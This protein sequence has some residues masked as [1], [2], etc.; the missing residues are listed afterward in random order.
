MEAGSHPTELL[1]SHDHDPG[2]FTRQVLTRDH[3]RFDP[4]GS[5]APGDL[6]GLFD[7]LHGNG[8]SGTGVGA[9]DLHG[10]SGGNHSLAMPNLQTG[11]LS[12]GMQDGRV[13]WAAVNQSAQVRFWKL[14][15][16]LGP[17]DVSEFLKLQ[18]PHDDAFEAG[19]T[20]QRLADAVRPQLFPEQRPL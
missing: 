17:M 6:P 1:E 7:V 18:K 19:G 20:D 14:G 16:T 5:E 11:M 2:P 15:R 12:D 9:D 13:D 10:R 4:G 8:R 3:A